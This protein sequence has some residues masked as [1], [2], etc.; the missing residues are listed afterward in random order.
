[1]QEVIERLDEAIV[2]MKDLGEDSARAAHAFEKKMAGLRL[3]AR[4]SQELMQHGK[5][6]ATEKEAWAF[7]QADVESLQADIAKNAF[8]TQRT[9][10]NA[11]MAESETLRSLARSSRDMHDSPGWGANAQ[12]RPQPASR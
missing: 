7:L 2:E 5:P 4:V 9:V 1:M 3:K 12:R 10:I 6:T 11:L 8:A